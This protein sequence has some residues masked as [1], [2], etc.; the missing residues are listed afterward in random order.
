MC[1]L[2]LEAGRIS[3][4]R[5]LSLAQC[6]VYVCSGS[7]SCLFCFVVMALTRKLSL[8]ILWPPFFAHGCFA[9]VRLS[10]TSR[11]SKLLTQIGHNRKLQI[12]RERQE[13]RCTH[14]QK[15]CISLLN[16][17]T[18]DRKRKKKEVVHWVMC[19]PDGYIKWPQHGLLDCK[20]IL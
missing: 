7:I 12:N 15:P 16:F 9:R 3:F 2:A 18:T 4:L 1:F 19:I 14:Y 6:L 20:T 10:F 11:M 17:N 13:A 5:V 8:K